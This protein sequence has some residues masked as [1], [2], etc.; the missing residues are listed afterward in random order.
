MGYIAGVFD[1]LRKLALFVVIG[2]L[3]LWFPG[4]PLIMGASCHDKPTIDALDYILSIFLPF[5]GVIVGVV[6]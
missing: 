3:L 1:R 4:G 6:C 2:F 5:Y